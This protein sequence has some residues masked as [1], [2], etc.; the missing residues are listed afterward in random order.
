MEPAISSYA[1]DTLRMSSLPR[2]SSQPARVIDQLR[3][4]TNYCIDQYAIQQWAP[5]VGAH[6]VAGVEPA[7]QG[8]RRDAQ[9]VLAGADSPEWRLAFWNEENRG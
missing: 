9:Q 5:A 1:T 6:R 3:F 7:W 8:G 2:V 4:K